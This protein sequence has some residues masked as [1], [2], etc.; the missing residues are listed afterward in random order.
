MWRHDWTCRTKPK[1]TKKS[2]TICD[3]LF[4]SYFLKCSLMLKSFLMCWPEIFECFVFP[5]DKHL[6]VR[7]GEVNKMQTCVMVNVYLPWFTHCSNLGLGI[8][9]WRQFMVQK[10]ADVA[11]EDSVRPPDLVRFCPIRSSSGTELSAD[12]LSAWRDVVGSFQQ[13]SWEWF[14]MR[15]G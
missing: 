13:R 2:P 14:N 10:T 6:P 15:Y 1:D 12:C 5:S 11:L 8:G 9:A 7:V 4:L 3:F